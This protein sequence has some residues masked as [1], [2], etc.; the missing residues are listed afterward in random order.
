M[1]DHILYL[2]IYNQD[3]QAEALKIDRLGKL[4]TSQ[5]GI[6]G[7]ISNVLET[8]TNRIANGQRETYKND[9]CLFNVR[10][11]KRFLLLGGLTSCDRPNIRK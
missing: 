9:L 3:T 11:Y 1:P 8:G 7:E 4:K 6:E 2:A 5:P 10:G